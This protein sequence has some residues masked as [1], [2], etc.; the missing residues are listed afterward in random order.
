MGYKQME[1]SLHAEIA[2]RIRDELEGTLER[3]TGWK[4]SAVEKLMRVSVWGT[5]P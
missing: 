3:K 5:V 2:D 4:E 1:V